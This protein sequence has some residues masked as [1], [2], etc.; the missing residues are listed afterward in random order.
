MPRVL[1]L[2]LSYDGSAYA[3]W[4]RQTNGQSIQG[5]IEE[6]LSRIDGAP[7][8]VA[9]AGRTDAG[10][11]ALGQVASARVA[12]SLDQP[13]LKRA[14]NAILPPDVR[15]VSVED[16]ADQFHARFSASGKTYEYWIW[17]GDVLPPLL[18]AS[19]WHV[20]RVLDVAAMDAAARLLEGRHD[21]AAFQS[22]GSDVKTSVRTI[23]SARVAVGA[24][25]SAGVASPF[26]S[27]TSDSQ[28]HPVVVRIEAD[29]FLRHM[30]RAVVGTL[31]EVGD[32][33]RAVDSIAALL[34]RPDRREAGP[35]AP[36]RGLVLVRVD[37][38]PAVAPGAGSR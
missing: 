38:R 19:C 17:Q 34:G 31:V 18:R 10:V 15:V 11:H 7:V 14:L 35:T 29:G 3:G 36:P 6:A 9:G 22:A 16:V 27:V 2:T 5:L 26:E 32:H 37:Y 8:V 12:T 23:W 20:P 21:F 4:Q 25:R 33:R 28:G 30:V 13:T 1:K 24:V